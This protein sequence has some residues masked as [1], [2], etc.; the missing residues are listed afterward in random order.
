META[1]CAAP[2][3]DESKGLGRAWTKFRRRRDQEVL[4]ELSAMNAS[5]RSPSEVNQL[6]AY[7]YARLGKEMQARKDA[8]KSPIKVPRR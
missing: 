7:A 1:S 3:G 8:E 2:E 6:S 5:E 4:D